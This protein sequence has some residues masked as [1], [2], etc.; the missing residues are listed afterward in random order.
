M[1]L[2]NYNA[3]VLKVVDGDTVKMRI[4]LGFCIDWETNAR[5]AGI[6][7]DELKA[8]DPILKESAYKAKEYMESILKPGDRIRIRSKTLDK[9][10]RPIVE[11]IHNGV[12]I[13]KE[14]LEK[15]LVKEYK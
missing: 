1:E 5:L 15:G 8:D 10:K 2:Y 4:D 3:T 12:N 9:Y 13:N 7:A 6:N 14:L 11:L